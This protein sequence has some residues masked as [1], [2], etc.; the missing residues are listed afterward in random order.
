[1]TWFEGNRMRE[2][3]KGHERRVVKNSIFPGRMSCLKLEI[4]EIAV[5]M[6]LETESSKPGKKK[7]KV[8]KSENLQEMGIREWGRMG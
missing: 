8:L 7:L 2:V 6:L 1:M 5:K 4:Q 3:R